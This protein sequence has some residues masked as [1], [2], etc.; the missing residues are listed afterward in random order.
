MKK[1]LLVL[2]L[3]SWLVLPGCYS[4]ESWNHFWGNGPR[5]AFPPDK[6]F[7]DKDCKPL[8]AKAEPAKPAPAKPVVKT[9]CGVSS[10]TTGYPCD[11][12]AVIRLEKNMPGEVAMNTKFDYT[13]RVVNPTG[14]MASDVVV[15][16]NLA[17]GF[18]MTDS[19]P[20]ASSADGGEITFAIG[21]LG[22]GQ[23]KVITISGMATSTNCLKSCATVTYVVPTCASVKVVQPALKLVKTAPASVLICDPIP[24]KFVVSNTGSGSAGEVK[25]EDT[26]P[27]GLKTSDGKGAISINVGTLAAG[28]SKEYSATLKA[29]KTGKYVNKAVASSSTGLKAESSTTTDVRQPVLAVSKS[30]PD[31]QYIGKTVSYKIVVTNKG[32]TAATDTVLTDSIPSGVSAVN[33]SDGGKVSGSSIVW[34]I[35]TLAAGASKTVTV[36]YSAST[37]GTISNTAKATAECAEGVS[38][39]AKTTI[40]G[41]AAVL[42]EVI[43]VE[44]PVEVGNN[45][46][47]V[48]TATNQGSM[49]DTNIRI[50]CMLEDN[51]Q[52]VSSSGAT[53]GSLSGNTITFEPLPTL[54]PKAQ[55]TWRVTVK[56]V[57]AGDVRFTVVMN[58]GQ[59]TRPVQET[60]ATNLYE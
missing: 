56:A 14:S 33:A 43:D 5:E 55:A 34:N 18:K 30:G 38:A 54:A 9:E 13:I 16:E 19:N 20:K 28:Q 42:L 31:Q 3:L 41:I 22:P 23:T 51:Q 44:D 47:Y 29:N 59:I 2:M 35:G 57:K 27:A 10:A 45:E 21:E 12:C 7:W 60:E 25:I 52:Y 53:R 6:V 8:V 17:A 46:T 39:S 11:G 4:C 58:T 50:V 15:V 37:A 49:P 48:I 36:S 24:V 1:M 32:D 40:T 26:L